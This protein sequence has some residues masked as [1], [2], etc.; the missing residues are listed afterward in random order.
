MPSVRI[1]ENE[2]YDIALRRFK[3]ACEKAGL[4]SEMRQREHYEKPTQVR[5]RKL[6]AAKKRAQK[7]I[8]RDDPIKAALFLRSRK[9]KKSKK[10]KSGAN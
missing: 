9:S 6:A 5:Q 1:R 10:A 8:I 3:R 7:K 2:P 4:M